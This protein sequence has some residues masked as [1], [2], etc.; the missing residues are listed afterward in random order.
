MKV[1]QSRI[2]Y[3]KDN[4]SQLLKDIKEKGGSIAGYGAPTKST[5]LMNYFELDK[6]LIDYIIDD[7]PLKQDKYS[8]LLH[9]PVVS[10]D[11]LLGDSQPD[12]LLI[13]AWNF[14]E[15]IIEKVKNSNN[16]TGKYI[17]PLPNAKIVW[18]LSYGYV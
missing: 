4:L 1:F 2:D 15:S 12:Y 7:N 13:L 10:S 3:A 16:F 18:G 17:I 11:H 14:A 9:I 5:T 8:P 6:G